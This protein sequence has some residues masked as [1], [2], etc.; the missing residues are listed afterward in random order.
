MKV[1]LLVG[2]SG[3]RISQAPGDV[4]D[5]SDAEGKRMIEAGQA[6]PAGREETAA[7]KET[8]T[9]KPATEKASK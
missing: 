1:K 2:R 7:K 6:V 3:P 9:R 4:V 5:V 8:A